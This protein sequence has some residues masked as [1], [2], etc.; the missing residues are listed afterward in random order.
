M[1]W[2]EDQNRRKSE[3]TRADEEMAWNT[4]LKKRKVEIELARSAALF[5]AQM[6]QNNDAHRNLMFTER[7]K[8]RNE[9]RDTILDNSHDRSMAIISER[10]STSMAMHRLSESHYN[11]GMKYMGGW[12]TT[13]SS[14]SSSSSSSASSATA[15]ISPKKDAEGDFEEVEEEETEDMRYFSGKM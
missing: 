3:Y 10:S 9:S 5:N 4:D 15:L 7:F 8:L 13:S 6:N 14:T 12:P 1:A 11:N 2:K